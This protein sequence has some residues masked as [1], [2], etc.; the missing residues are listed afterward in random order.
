MSNRNTVIESRDSNILGNIH[1]HRQRLENET[2]IRRY[3]FL[4]QTS[5]KHIDK[6]DEQNAR[7]IEYCEPDN[8]KTG[9]AYFDAAQYTQRK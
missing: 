8:S 5:D 9:G 3:E 2:V 1:Q 7:E 4:M 6:W